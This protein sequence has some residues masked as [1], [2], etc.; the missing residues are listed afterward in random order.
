MGMFNDELR[1][2]MGPK[3]NTSLNTDGGYRRLEM[4]CSVLRFGASSIGEVV[5]KAFGKG[6]EICFSRR[7]F[8]NERG[9]P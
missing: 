3:K 8:W 9:A 1:T 4:I 2:L 6:K 5:R 7:S